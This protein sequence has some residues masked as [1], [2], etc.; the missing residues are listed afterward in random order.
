MEKI[1]CGKKAHPVRFFLAVISLLPG[2]AIVCWAGN[3]E[4]LFKVEGWERAEQ[5]Q[6]FSPQT[7]YNYI[8]GG[9]DLYLK[10]DFQ[11][12]RVVEY[13]NEKGASVTIEIYRHRTSNQA[14]GIYSQERLP[15]AHYLPIG[16]QGYME[17]DFLNFI[18]GNCYVKMSS[19]NVG[20]QSREVLFTFA[21]KVLE[22]LGER[23]SLPAVLSLFPDEGKKKNTEKFVA[24]DFLGYSFLHSGFIV[25]YEISGGK[26]QL[27][28]IEGSDVQDAAGM[29]RKYLQQLGKASESVVEGVY[30]LSDPY[31]GPVDLGWKGK[32]IW[33]VLS[34]DDP[35]LRSRYLELLREQIPSAR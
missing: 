18:T 22:N 24:R 35:S 3:S 2:I 5:V 28:I 19:H 15:Q 25:N 13:R 16:A 34:L 31:H 17:E 10:Y 21:K 32:Y 9:A 26:F 4:A 8:N 6:I 1:S 27:F 33:G 23:G 30:R 14:F 12:L 29:M 7:L 20:P 11:E